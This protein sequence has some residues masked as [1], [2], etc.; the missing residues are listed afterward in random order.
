MSIHIQ[1]W[2]GSGLILIKIFISNDNEQL[3]NLCR[4]HDLSKMA[5]WTE[6]ETGALIRALPLK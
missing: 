2:F 3:K 6:A 5:G 4:S 1:R